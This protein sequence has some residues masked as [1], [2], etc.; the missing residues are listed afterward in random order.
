MKAEHKEIFKRAFFIMM[1]LLII[2]HFVFWKLMSPLSTLQYIAVNSLLIFIISVVVE[3]IMR[4][5]KVDRFL[6]M[7]LKWFS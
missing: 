1:L 5:T 4:I 2:L 6:S 3:K 7:K